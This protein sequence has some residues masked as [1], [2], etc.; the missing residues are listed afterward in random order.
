M[1][2]HLIFQLTAGEGCSIM[3]MRIVLYQHQNEPLFAKYFFLSLET[4][5]IPP[6]SSNN[7]AIKRLSSVRYFS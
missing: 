1:A 3:G 4:P 6:V 2:Q 5:D 7:H